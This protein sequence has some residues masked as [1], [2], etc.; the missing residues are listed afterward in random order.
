MYSKFSVSFVTTGLL[1]GSINYFDI[2]YIIFV[3]L[4]PM[5]PAGLDW[6]G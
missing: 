6:I 4:N 1:G 2:F 3:M 5:V